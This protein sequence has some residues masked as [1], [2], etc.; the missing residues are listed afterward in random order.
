MLL[1]SSVSQNKRNQ[2]G[3]CY[4]GQFGLVDIRLGT[5]PLGEETKFT[6]R[7]Q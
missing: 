3:D 4:I 6:R 5:L 7:G 2:G 1:V